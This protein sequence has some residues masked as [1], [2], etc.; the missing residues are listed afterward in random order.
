[1]R[2]PQE[3]LRIG[4]CAASLLVPAACTNAVPRVPKGLHPPSGGAFPLP[5]DSRPPL[6]QIQAITEQPSSSCSWFDGEWAWQ[7]NTWIWR[8]GGWVRVNDDCYYAESVLTWQGGS[9]S[10]GVLY[11]TPGQWYHRTSL[12]RCAPPIECSR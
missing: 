9:G 5:V 4:L 7:R 1:M 10:S 12:E 8:E 2:W 6:P 3:A 11:F